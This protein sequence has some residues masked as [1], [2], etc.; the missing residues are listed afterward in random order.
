MMPCLWARSQ[1]DTR[2]FLH[3]QVLLWCHNLIRHSTREKIDAVLEYRYCI[4]LA[5]LEN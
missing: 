4:H 2:A 5:D 1:S 3:L